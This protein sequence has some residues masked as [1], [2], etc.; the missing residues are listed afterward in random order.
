MTLLPAPQR[1]SFVF[2]GSAQVLDHVVVTADLV[3]TNTG[4]VYAHMDSDFPLVYLNDANRPERI[5]DHDPAVAYFT[6]P[7]VAGTV[8]LI[9]RSTLTRNSDG[10][11]QAVLT[12][13][14]TER[15]LLWQCS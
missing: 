14:N 5:S 10:G 11:Y 6:V 8:S 1:Q 9:T 3:P 2:E 12:I 13:T 15:A 4:L 7:P